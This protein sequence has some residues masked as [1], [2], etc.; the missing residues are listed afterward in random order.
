MNTLGM[1]TTNKRQE[2][3][4]QYCPVKPSCGWLF[5]S[6]FQQSANFCLLRTV[7]A[8]LPCPHRKFII[9]INQ[10]SLLT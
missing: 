8:Q 4:T 7:C 10:N 9:K 6:Q 3:A 5:A 1:N 2:N